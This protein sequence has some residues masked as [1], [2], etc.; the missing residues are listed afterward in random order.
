VDHH[1][2]QVFITSF[3][4]TTEIVT[5]TVLLDFGINA[6]QANLPKEGGNDECAT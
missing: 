1:S 5:A 2:A 4:L 3:I 6:V